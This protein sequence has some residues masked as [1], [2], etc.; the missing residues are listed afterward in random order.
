M[1][2]LALDMP[3]PPALETDVWSGSRF[4]RE[5]TAGSSFIFAV[6]ERALVRVWA[7]G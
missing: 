7:K 1:E 5:R 2:V 4:R 3:P 6:E